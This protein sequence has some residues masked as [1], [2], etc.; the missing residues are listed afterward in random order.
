MGMVQQSDMVGTRLPFVDTEVR[1][2]MP[3]LALPVGRA[4]AIIEDG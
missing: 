2:T 3:D 4:C 1:C